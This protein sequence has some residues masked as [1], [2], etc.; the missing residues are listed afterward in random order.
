MKYEEPD[1][2]REIH[3]IREQIYE[4]IKDMS[5]EERVK[6]HERRSREIEENMLERGYKMIPSETPGCKRLVRI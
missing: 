3:E 4:E 5:L 2:M 6:Y 1:A